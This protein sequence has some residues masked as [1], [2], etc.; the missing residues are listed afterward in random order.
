MSNEVLSAALDLLSRGFTPL[1]ANVAF[2]NHGALKCTCPNPK[3]P[4]PGKHPAVKWRDFQENKPTARQLTEWFSGRFELYNLCVVHGR[5]SN[6][7]LL[8]WDGEPGMD[9]LHNMQQE[10][11]DLPLTPTV[12]TGGGGMHQV[13]RHPGVIVPTRKGL[14]DGFDVRGDGGISVLPPS[15]HKNGR[16]YEW[17]VD[18]HLEDVPIAELPP[19]WLT[20]ILGT[21]PAKTTARSVE[22]PLGGVVRAVGAVVD[23]RE[24][25]MRDVVYR[26]F[27][28]LQRALQRVPTGDELITTAWADYAASTDLSRPGRG[29][30]AMAEK[31][32]AILD[33]AAGR[34]PCRLTEP[35][36]FF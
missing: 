13:F 15:L 2:V 3:C 14:C 12:L 33:H 6:T 8:D 28:A 25:H 18:A 36:D 1:P 20:M 10:L 7:V 35:P 24:T 23:G 31:C 27:C 19:R 16:L 4:S 9:M 5:M 22:P 26:S 17:D 11:G 32:Q 21:M 30:A 29:H 34:L